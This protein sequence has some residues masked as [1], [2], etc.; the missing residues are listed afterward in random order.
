MLKN[1]MK[2]LLFLVFIATKYTLNV[3][4]EYIYAHT[5]TYRRIIML[6]LPEIK[7][8]IQMQLVIVVILVIYY[9]SMYKYY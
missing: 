4:V 6:C 7:Q 3:H 2:F 8:K 1:I 5:N 9:N